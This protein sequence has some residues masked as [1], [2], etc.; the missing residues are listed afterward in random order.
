M[1]IRIKNA[2]W[3]TSVADFELSNSILAAKM[4]G[5]AYDNMTDAN[6]DPILHRTSLNTRTKNRLRQAGKLVLMIAGKSILKKC[7]KNLTNNR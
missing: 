4:S 7:C 1:Y 3:K 2:Y 5:D 6:G